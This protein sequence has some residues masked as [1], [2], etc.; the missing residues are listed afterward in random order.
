MLLF[1]KLL[2]KQPQSQPSQIY[3]VIVIQTTNKPTKTT[4]KTF[5]YLFI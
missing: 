1:A 3:E 5:G 2:L 4:T